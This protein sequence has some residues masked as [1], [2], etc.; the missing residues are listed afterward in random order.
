MRT[1]EGGKRIPVLEQTLKIIAKL[2]SLV[3]EPG[4]GILGIRFLNSSIQ[5]DYVSENAANDIV[6]DHHY[7][8][9]TRI[10]GELKRKILRP[11]V[12]DTHMKKPLL[13]MTIT[14]GGVG[15]LS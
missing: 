4:R 7:S 2:Y 8:G 1:E 9:L 3:A 10:G 11:F 12:Y 5:K 13:I 6:K 14:D 15:F